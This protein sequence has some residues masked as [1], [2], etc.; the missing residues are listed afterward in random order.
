M[1]F[2]MA[3]AACGPAVTPAA[4]PTPQ[5]LTIETTIT[6][7]PLGEVFNRCIAEQTGAALVLIEKP[8]HALM[9]APGQTPQAGQA[10]VPA[11]LAIRWG[12]DSAPDGFAAE[13]G[14]EELVV[15]AHPQ[16][17]LMRIAL[18]DLLAMYAG[19][20]RTWPGTSGE[21][22]PWVYPPGEDV[23]EV[24]ESAA[25]GGAEFSSRAAYLAPDT[26]AMRQAVSE[27]S[28]ALGF[29]PR[30]WVDDS[31]KELVVEGLDS[32][33][34][35]RPYVVLSPS[36]PGGLTENWLLCVQEGING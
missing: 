16:N 33:Q 1:L 7:R 21:V 32:A 13:L 25:A 36:E 27:N 11:D 26:E 4:V 17:P 10:S 18:S 20:Q 6:L 31:V 3:A 28:Q 24:F 30:R 8:A 19:T 23:Q 29:L 15:I 14:Q 5:V 9:A 35:R 12:L 34:M 22:Q 2:L